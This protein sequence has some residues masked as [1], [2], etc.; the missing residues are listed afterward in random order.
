ME[1][2][3]NEAAKAEAR[4]RFLAELRSGN[5]QQTYKMFVS[6][7][8][9]K[10]S[11]LGVAFLSCG[12]KPKDGCFSFEDRFATYALLGIESDV[13]RVAEWNNTYQ[14]PFPAIADK[15]EALWSLE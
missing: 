5:H 1:S 2:E 14:L 6:E 7:D 15:L 13:H 10:F 11:A 8:E 4:Q 12:Y 3:V 9:C